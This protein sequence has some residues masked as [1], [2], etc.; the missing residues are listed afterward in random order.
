M[1]RNQP[2]RVL[3]ATPLGNEVAPASSSRHGNVG[4]TVSPQPK[5]HR[6]AVN[7]GRCE[8]AV[9]RV[10]MAGESVVGGSGAALAGLAIRGVL[11]ED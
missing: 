5:R 10:S 2:G 3:S 7:H 11:R 6:G 8:P 1:N 4:A 9:M